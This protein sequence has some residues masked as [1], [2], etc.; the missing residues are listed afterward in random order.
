MRSRG[1]LATALI[2]VCA[3]AAAAAAQ[4]LDGER[5]V[6][7]TGA[8][9]GFVNEHPAVPFHLGFGLGL[10]LNYADDQVVEVDANDN[11][12]SRPGHTGLTADLLASLGLF[13]RVE[14]GLH[15][16]LHLIY[17]GDPYGGLAASAGL[18]DLRLVPK[19]A[20]VRAGSLE[21]HFMLGLALPVSFPTGDD[22]ALRG[23]GG[24]TLGAQLLL[25]VH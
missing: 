8:E 23:A 25:A 3:L 5:F 1:V 15:L 17:D 13:G 21:R 6:P 19:I 11:I 4:G 20:L 22:E 7:A 9:G 10:F 18:G 12:V 2:C 14:L 16:P 24:V